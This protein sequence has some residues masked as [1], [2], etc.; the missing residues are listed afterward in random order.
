[1]RMV[2]RMNWRM[3]M[4][5]AALLSMMM[6]LVEE[7]QSN[8][9]NDQSQHRNSYQPIILDLYRLEYPLN[10]LTKYVIANEN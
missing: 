2:V 3:R 8:P 7:H 4:P 5:M 10:A 9:I 1:M 6:E